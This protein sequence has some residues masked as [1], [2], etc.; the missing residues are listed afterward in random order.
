[1]HD[2]AIV[3]RYQNQYEKAERL[4]GRALQSSEKRLGRDHPNTLGTV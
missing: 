3:Y 1:V 4:Y 2:F